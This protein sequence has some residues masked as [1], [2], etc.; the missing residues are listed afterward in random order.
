MKK[1]KDLKPHE[2]E[3]L[4]N[5]LLR[6]E[7]IQ[8]RLADAVAYSWKKHNEKIVEN[9]GGLEGIQNICK[10]L[11][12]HGLTPEQAEKMSPEEFGNFLTEH[13]INVK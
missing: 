12:E 2:K 9:L 1:L 7:L 3:I 5:E 6:E 4:N 8:Q 13:D 10:Q 11:E